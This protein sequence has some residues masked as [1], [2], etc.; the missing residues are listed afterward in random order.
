[1]R[2]TVAPA[3][4]R[5]TSRAAGAASRAV[6]SGRQAP[7]RA[8]ARIWHAPPPWRAPHNPQIRGANPSHRPWRKATP[9][10]HRNRRTM[11]PNRLHRRPNRS[12]RSPRWARKKCRGPHN[13]HQHRHKCGS[14]VGE[15]TGRQC[16][17]PTRRTKRHTEAMRH[18]PL[19]GLAQNLMD[20]L[21]TPGVRTVSTDP[22]LQ[23]A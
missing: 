2:R 8:P 16:R 12:A 21:R 4:P 9:R 19:A 14:L 17:M 7:A 10:G 23:I 15:R 18:W 20:Q 13:G 3:A 5:P 22:Q 1:M 6:I 11:K